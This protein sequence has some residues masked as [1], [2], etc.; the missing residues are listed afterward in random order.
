MS[1]HSAVLVWKETELKFFLRRE[2]TS[3][4]DR[5]INFLLYL[6]YVSC[7]FAVYVVNIFLTISTCY[8]YCVFKQDAFGVIFKFQIRRELQVRRMT[9]VS[10]KG[11]N[12]R[13]LPHLTSPHLT[14][15]R[16][17][18][19]FLNV[20]FSSIQNSGQWTKSSK[21]VIL[22]VIHHRQNSLGCRNDQVY[23]GVC[24][25]TCSV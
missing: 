10:S 12:S 2:P 13:S 22:S 6:K 8:Y 14:W 1:C 5:Q 3:S 21:P 9:E 11:P 17:R 7:C 16:N 23:S 18:Y 4:L 20:M 15:R 24:N 25:V 19:S